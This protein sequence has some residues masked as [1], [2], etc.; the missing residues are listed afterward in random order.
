MKKPNL[1]IVGAARSGTTTLWQI[2][3]ENPRVFMPDNLMLKEPAHFSECRKLRFHHYDKYKKIF[4]KANENHLWVGEASTA[5]LTDPVSSRKIFQYNPDARI[6]IILRNPVL[7]AYSLYRW[8][9]Q[10]GYEYANTFEDALS[11]EESRRKKEIPNFF[12]P[13]YYYNYLYFNS[14]KYY[15]QVK[16]YLRLFKENV[17]I[18]K[19]ENFIN[20]F[21]QEYGRICEFLG[22]SQNSFNITK[23]NESHDVVSP[24]QQFILRKITQFYLSNYENLKRKNNRTEF[25]NAFIEELSKNII[26]LKKV[27]HIGIFQKMRL[28]S[29]IEKVVKRLSSGEWELKKDTIQNRDIIMKCG[30]KKKFS[31][32]I[33]EETAFNLKKK[34][35]DDILQLCQY[36]GIDFS[37]WVV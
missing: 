12:E 5:Y 11:L 10:D 31:K 24:V 7:R 25:K 21:S 36:T 13:E 20:N 3:K 33:K 23:T 37:G 15:H 19:F 26:Q 6:I 28:L 34:Y 27:T 18:L 16:R 22:I 2:L 29:I 35:R 9:V 30:L 4:E 32:R 8:M 14:G 17:I 1:F